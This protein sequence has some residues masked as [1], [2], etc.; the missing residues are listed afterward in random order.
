M[1]SLD[2]WILIFWRGLV[3]CSTAILR[4]LLNIKRK[5]IVKL[6]WGKRLSLYSAAHR[7]VIY[8]AKHFSLNMLSN[9]LSAMVISFINYV[10]PFG[11]LPVTTLALS[12]SIA[13]CAVKS[14]TVPFKIRFLFNSQNKKMQSLRLRKNLWCIRLSHFRYHRV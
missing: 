1:R 7:C 12:I 2:W 4:N 13:S 10:L 8:H 11:S 6:K 5:Y 3:M 9:F 14:I